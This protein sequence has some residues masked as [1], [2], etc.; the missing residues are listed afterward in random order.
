M[1]KMLVFVDH[2]SYKIALCLAHK[3]MMMNFMNFIEQN[4]FMIVSMSRILSYL[5]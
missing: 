1:T 2:T 3:K 4:K 5:Q